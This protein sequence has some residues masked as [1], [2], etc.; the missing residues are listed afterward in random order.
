MDISPAQPI[1]DASSIRF[2]EVPSSTNETSI[3]AIGT[4]WT[5][6]WVLLGILG[7]VVITGIVLLLLYAFPSDQ[8]SSSASI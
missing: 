5:W 7:V 4:N 3:N 8:H 6:L 1:V 2:V